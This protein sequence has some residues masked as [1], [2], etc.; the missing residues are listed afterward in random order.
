MFIWPNGIHNRLNNGP[1]KTLSSNPYNLETILYM[2]SF[3]FLPFSQ[4]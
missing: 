3:F 2:E 4:M 1:Q